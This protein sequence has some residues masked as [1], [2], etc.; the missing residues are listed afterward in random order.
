MTDPLTRIEEYRSQ[1]L[2]LANKAYFNYGGQG[3]LPQQA[4][5]AIAQSYRDIQQLGPFSG[6]TNAWIVRE[7]TAT[8]EAIAVEL[9]VPPHTITLTENVSVGCNIVLWGLPWQAGDGILI[10]DCEHPSI[11]A[12][13]RELQ[14]RFR[15]E[16]TVCPLRETLNRGNPVEVLAQHLTSHTRL[17]VLSHILWNTGQVLPLDRLVRVCHDWGAQSMH[18]RKAKVLVDA[19]QSVGVLPLK[20]TRSDVDFYAFTGHKWWCGPEG[21]GGLYISSEAATSLHPTFIGWRGIEVNET[22]EPIRFKPDG[23][24]FEVATSAYPLYAGLRSAIAVHHQWGTAEER[25]QKICDRSKLLWEKLQTFP[26]VHCLRNSPPECGLV[27]F[28]LSSKP[29]ERAKVHGE[30]VKFLEREQQVMVRTI[31]NPNCVRACVHYFTTDEEIEQLAIGID[32]F[33]RQFLHSR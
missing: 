9:G 7:A 22:G 5:E 29:E 1:F 4:L 3:P 26:E 6:Q 32:R 21:L 28:Q 16:V 24:A 19:A 31:L 10:T 15:L 27:S 2:A 25:Y 20:L 14:R 13:V 8:R 17:I 11:V 23:R 18:S 33:L 30:L 12:A